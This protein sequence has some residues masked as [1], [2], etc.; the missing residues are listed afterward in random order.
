[1][2]KLTLAV[3]LT[4]DRVPFDSAHQ[5]HVAKQ[6]GVYAFIIRSNF[7]DLPP[8]GYVMYI[9][10]TGI[11]SK[12][13]T[14]DVRYGEYLKH[15][16]VVKS[17]K[18]TGINHMLRIWRDCLHFFYAPLAP[19]IDLKQLEIALNDCLIPPFVQNDFS[20]TIKDAKKAAGLR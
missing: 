3:N 17:K 12:T 4:W 9:G 13:R 8:H 18:R 6:R 11:T 14:L 15:Q 16:K 19:G 5:K 1:M 10:I 7:A 2:A 20:A